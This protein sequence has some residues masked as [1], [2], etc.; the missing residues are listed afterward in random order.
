MLVCTTA[1]EWKRLQE[2]WRRGLVGPFQWSNY[3]D[4]CDAVR[5]LMDGDRVAAQMTVRDANTDSHA[6]DCERMYQIDSGLLPE[7]AAVYMPTEEEWLEL[8]ELSSSGE[9]E[10]AWFERMG[11]PP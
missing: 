6:L 4:G 2:A 7:I 10:S 8:D 1:L 11:W 3:S 9:D 5:R